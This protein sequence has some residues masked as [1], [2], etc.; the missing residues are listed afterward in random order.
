MLG[1]LRKVKFEAF[2]CGYANYPP[3]INGLGK[4]GYAHMGT[5]RIYRG[6]VVTSTGRI[7]P[8]SSVIESNFDMVDAFGASVPNLV[9]NDLFVIAS[10]F[11]KHMHACQ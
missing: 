11:A 1:K 7:K 5:Y 8:S 9:L 6:A 4:L 3:K 2:T 10:P